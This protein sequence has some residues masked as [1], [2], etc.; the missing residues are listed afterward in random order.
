MGQCFKVYLLVTGKAD[1][2][3][4]WIVTGKADE[5]RAWITKRLG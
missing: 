1:E 3:R 5:L 4:A 2:L